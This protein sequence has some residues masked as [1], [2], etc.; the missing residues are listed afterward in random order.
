MQNVWCLSDIV[1]RL[2]GHG[3]LGAAILALAGF[4]VV[5]MTGDGVALRGGRPARGGQCTSIE[6]LL[7]LECR[8][9][10][11]ESLKRRD[12]AEALA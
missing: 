1:R 7:R 3:A 10:V 4:S 8:D 12:G 6:L 11:N 2:L 9:K 5:M